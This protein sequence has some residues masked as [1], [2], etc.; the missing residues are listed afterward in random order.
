[1]KLNLILE[2]Y[3]Q[4]CVQYTGLPAPQTE[5]NPEILFERIKQF[6]KTTLKYVY[7]LDDWLNRTVYF[8]MV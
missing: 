1:M 4:L 7:T 2:I 3:I 5:T 8:P 6:N